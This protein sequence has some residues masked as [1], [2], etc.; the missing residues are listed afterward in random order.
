MIRVA[1]AFV[2]RGGLAG[3][4]GNLGGALALNATTAP[5]KFCGLLLAGAAHSQHDRTDMLLSCAG[6]A[7]LRQDNFRHE[8]DNVVLGW[9]QHH[10]TCGSKYAIVG[11][12]TCDICVGLR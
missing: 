5:P 2:N 7:Q 3:D 8:C 12:F 4:T 10:K 1:L 11:G 9:C 6:V